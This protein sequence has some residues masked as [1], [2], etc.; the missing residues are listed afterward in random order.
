MNGGTGDN[1]NDFF[2]CCCVVITFCCLFM[3][4]WT[5]SYF[6]ICNISRVQVKWPNWMAGTGTSWPKSELSSYKSQVLLYLYT[7]L[8]YAH[9]H[10]MIMYLYVFGAL[11][12]Q[13][14]MRQWLPI[15]HSHLPSRWRARLAVQL[16]FLS[17][18]WKV[19][20]LHNRNAS[21]VWF[22]RLRWISL[23]SRWVMKSRIELNMSRIEQK[24][25]DFL[26]CDMT[27]TLSSTHPLMI[28]LNQFYDRR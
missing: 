27:R 7:L 23:V 3:F 17:M 26:L 5:L 18:Q 15:S 25:S 22:L 19:Q 4:L 8:V 21:D 24:G 2:V 12:E 10:S 1:A 14:S 11:G 20:Y 6:P 13:I 9:I 16:A 28:L